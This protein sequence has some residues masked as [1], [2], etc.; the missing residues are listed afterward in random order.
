M[1]YGHFDDANREYVITTPLTPRPWIN[2]LGCEKLFG[3]ISSHG[4]GYTFYRDARLR[5]LTRYRY[6]NAGSPAGG[7][8]FYVHHNGDIW[9]PGWLPVKAALDTCEVRHGLGYTRITGERNGLRCSL[10]CFVPPAAPVEIHDVTLTN[11]SDRAHSFSLYSCIEFCLYNALDDMTNFQRN[12]NTGEVLVEGSTIFHLTEFRER[13]AHYAWYHGPRETSGFE[14]SRDSFLGSYNGYDSP[15]AVTQ[16]CATNSHA[17]GWSPMASHRVPVTLEGG[18]S[19]RLSFLLGYTEVDPAAKWERDGSANLS[20]ARDTIA[21]FATPTAIDAAF[22]ALRTYWHTLLDGFQVAT[23][24]ERVDRMVNIWNQYQCMV[25]FNLSR[26]ASFFESGIGR[27]MGFRDSNQDLL[28]FVHMA[29][30]R[31][32]ERILDIAATQ[33]RDGGCY[34]QYQPLT[35]KGNHEIGSGFNDDPLWLVL[36]VGAYLRET[37][38]AAL[39]DALVPWDGNPDDCASL[40]DHLSASMN[41]V[42]NN[43]GPHGLPLIGRADWNDCLNLNCFSTTPDESFQTGTSRDGTRAESL[44]IAG[45]FLYAAR[46]YASLCDL[47]G[48]ADERERIE[49]CAVSVREAIAHHGWDGE[50]FLRAWDDNGDPVGSRQ[51]AEGKLFI[52]SQGW[53]ILGGVGIEG[54]QARQALDSVERH[55]ATPHGIVLNTPAYTRYYLNLGEISTYPPGYKENGGI[56]CHNNPWIMIAETLIGRGEKAFDYWQRIAP[57]FREPLSDIH[58]LEPYVYAQMIAGRDSGR[59]GEAKNSWLTGAAAWNFVAISQHILGIRPEHD[60]LRIDPCIPAQWDGFRVTRRFRGATYCI[61]V[62]NSAHVSRGIASLSIDGRKLPACS[63]PPADS[64]TTCMVHAV[65]GHPATGR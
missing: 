28:G 12:L 25:T 22:G 20:G 49:A 37:A 31:A 5:R 8:Y 63:I 16:D 44:M 15:R 21:R 55:L 50:W 13:R 14:T 58:A 34:H 41:H 53:C 54:E 46:E 38:D 27:G 19:V 47:C 29:A 57:S 2:Y 1:R 40:F 10:L 33:F 17:Q 62:D 48:R 23:G 45:L 11:T 4:E 6:N 59:E 7:R 51:C 39:L 9:S 43:S 26:S 56:F 36:A 52:E 24:D 42:V 61:S 18:E 35:R 60:G 3:I 64:G 30:P 65:M 32:R